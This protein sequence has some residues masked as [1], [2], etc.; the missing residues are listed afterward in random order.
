V[1]AVAADSLETVPH[2]Q[3]ALQPLAEINFETGYAGLIAA[4]R[5]RAAERRIAIGGDSVAAVSGLAVAYVAKLLQPRPT[6]RIGAIS[7]GPLLGVL[8]LKLIVAA[9]SNALARFGSK[10][11]KRREE[12]VHSDALQVVVSRR[13]LKKIGAVGGKASRA[14]MSRAQARRLGMR[15]AAARSASL[16]PKQRSEIARRAAKA[17]WAKRKQNGAHITSV[18][19]IAL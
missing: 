4:F 12:C 11:E 5:A 13:F 6:K 14:N 16:S 3:M 1:L 9:D 8:G 19:E 2:D 17:R 15:G 18:G 7:L 10:L